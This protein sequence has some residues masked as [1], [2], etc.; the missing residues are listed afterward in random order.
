MFGDSIDRRS[1]THNSPCKWIGFAHGSGIGSSQ[2]V[3]C[4]SVDILAS[5]CRYNQYM[6]LLYLQTY[7]QL[8]HLCSSDWLHV[9]PI[10]CGIWFITPERKLFWIVKW[11]GRTRPSMF[12]NVM[13]VWTQQIESFFSAI[14]VK[15]P[16]D[17][18]SR[19]TI[20][21]FCYL[22]LCC[23]NVNYVVQGG[24]GAS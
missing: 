21:Q 16:G 11:R 3:V 15:M 9:H 18:S 20:L 22:Y 13:N 10:A 12:S 17:F 8:E 19:Y 4:S 1:H 14:S 6:H 2:D 7:K 5:H 24:F 23:R